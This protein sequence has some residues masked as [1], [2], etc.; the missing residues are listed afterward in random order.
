MRRALT[1]IAAVGLIALLPRT[2]ARPSGELALMP[3]PTPIAAAASGAVGIASWY[4]EDFDGNP[5]ASGELFDMNDLTAASPTLPLGTKVKVTNLRN[6]R[7]MVLRVNDRGPYFG[8]RLLDVSKAA[9]SRLGFLA[10]G[11]ALVHIQVIPRHKSRA[12]HTG[13]PLVPASGE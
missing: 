3:A 10:S 13:S 8:G 5:T 1:G 9:A 12:T 2:E 4:G 11:L 6:G 7:S